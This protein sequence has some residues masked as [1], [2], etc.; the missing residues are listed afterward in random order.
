MSKNGE[1]KIELADTEI[2]YLRKIHNARALQELTKQPGWEIYTGFV[3]DMINRFE[4]Q[5]LNYALNSSR[6][7]YWISG[8]RLAGV[9]QFAKILTEQIAKEVDILNHP[10]RPPQP[11]D[12]LDFDGDIRNGNHAEGEN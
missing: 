10:L 2:D 12:P 11:P 3:A 8:V 9:R 1:L 7:G 4:D 6:D 5:H